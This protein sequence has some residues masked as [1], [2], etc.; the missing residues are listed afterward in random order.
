MG[1]TVE[2]RPEQLVQFAFLG[3]AFMER[4]V[5]VERPRVGLL[6]V[7]E[8][9]SKGTPGVAEAHSRL[10]S[11]RAPPFEFVGNVEGGALTAGEADV[12]VTDGF[13]GNVAL[14]L[15]EGTT[16]RSW[17]RSATRCAPA[18]SRSSAAC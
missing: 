1:A 4:V 16:A 7:G 5:G 2:V 14:K 15:M 13:T 10:S 3:A 12:V 18:R 6:N 8:E 9:P 11:A 17:A